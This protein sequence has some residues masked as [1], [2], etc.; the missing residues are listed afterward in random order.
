MSQSKE[1]MLEWID[2]A[3]LEELLYK[4][5]FAEVGSPYFIGEVGEYYSKV[6][7]AKR[8]QDEAAWVAASKSLG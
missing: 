6:M 2:N 4:W 3:S 1:Q 7:F 5:R 8:Q